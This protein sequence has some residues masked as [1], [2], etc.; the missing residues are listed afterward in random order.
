MIFSRCIAFVVTVFSLFQIKFTTSAP[1]IEASSEGEILD[2]YDVTEPAV[3][4]KTTE[5]PSKNVILDMLEDTAKNP[6]KADYA[7]SV[8][9]SIEKVTNRPK[10][11]AEKQGGGGTLIQSFGDHGVININIILNNHTLLTNTS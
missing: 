1:Q 10:A 9:T 8:A 2:E 5:R 6:G 4:P 3:I 7:E 11:P